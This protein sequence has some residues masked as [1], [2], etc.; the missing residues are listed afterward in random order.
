MATAKVETYETPAEETGSATGAGA[1][2][3]G[4]KTWDVLKQLVVDDL[5]KTE[6]SAAG[7]VPSDISGLTESE[8]ASKFAFEGLQATNKTLADL[9]KPTQ[10][11]LSGQIPSDVTAQ[12][13]QITA[14]K[15]GS[16][17]LFGQA[18]RALLA[19]D[20]GKT[21]LELVQAGATMA[22][23]RAEIATRQTELANARKSF[24]ETLTL[25]RR[26]LNQKAVQTELDRA[27]FNATLN[28]QLMDLISKNIEAQQ[29]AAY[30]YSAGQMSPDN[31]VSSYRSWLDVLLKRVV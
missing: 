13:R 24:L 16:S 29:T 18:S 15:S 1:A 6:P 23:S 30:R 26:E 3:G 14:E 5:S 19:R 27:E 17:G 10:Q 2:F 31:V 22:A 11:L 20:L 8:L 25:Q 9:E 7:P 28:Y 21:S 12:I 4:Q